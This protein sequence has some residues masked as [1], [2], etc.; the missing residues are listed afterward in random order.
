MQIEVKMKYKSKGNYT[1]EEN[2]PALRSCAECNPAHKHL[3]DTDFLHCCFDCGRYWI[4]GKYLS[5]FE[6]E[7]KMDE[8]LK[9][10]LEAA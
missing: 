7:D 4:H 8:F 9:E 5:D 2:E 10:K 3:M 1:R 6:T